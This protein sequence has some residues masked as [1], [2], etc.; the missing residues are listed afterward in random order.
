MTHTEYHSRE[1]ANLVDRLSH[2]ALAP[3]SDR[4]EAQADAAELMR[5]TERVARNLQWLLEG[6][7]GYAEQQQ[8]QRI[9]ALKRGNREAQAMQLLAALDCFCPQRECIVAWKG[10]TVAEQSALS[11][12]IRA[13]LDLVEVES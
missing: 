9:Q 11:F 1:M 3:L 4:R 12:S 8:A 2:L 6:N 7:Y 5:D 10:L 13:V